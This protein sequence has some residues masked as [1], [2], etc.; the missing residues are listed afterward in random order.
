MNLGSLYNGDPM[1][2][3]EKVPQREHVSANSLRRVARTYLIE[4][5]VLV[6]SIVPVGGRD[7]AVKF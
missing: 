4:N 7:F 6:V 1:F 5:N 2:T 3:F